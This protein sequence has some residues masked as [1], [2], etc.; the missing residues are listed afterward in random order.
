[1]GEADGAENSVMTSYV[2]HGRAKGEG[3]CFTEMVNRYECRLFKSQPE[4]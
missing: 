4:P 2:I 1:M 3:D